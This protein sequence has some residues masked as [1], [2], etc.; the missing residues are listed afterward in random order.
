MKQVEPL[1][2]IDELLSW[3]CSSEE[4]HFLSKLPGLPKIYSGLPNRRRTM[5]CHDFKGGYRNDNFVQISD[6][7]KCDL[8][9][10]YI[11]FHWD[12]CDLF[13]YF[14]HCLVTIPPIGWICAAH[15]NSTPILGTFITEH[16]V[17]KIISM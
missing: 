13:V 14:S 3:G 17:E 11:F 8:Q 4:E 6:C 5:V 2:N 1:K 7:E 12:Y 10:D 9:N 15:R 16:K